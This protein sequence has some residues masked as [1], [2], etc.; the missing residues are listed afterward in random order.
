LDLIVNGNSR[1][2]N[3]WI[4]QIFSE[5]DNVDLTA[6]AECAKLVDAP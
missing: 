1:S 6:F 5:V 4:V 3:G 2:N